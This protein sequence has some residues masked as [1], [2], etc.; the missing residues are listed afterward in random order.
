[1]AH[2]SKQRKEVNMEQ[3]ELVKTAMQYLR[4]HTSYPDIWL[5][6]LSEKKLIAIYLSTKKKLAKRS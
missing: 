5:K 6:E 1:M 3:K 2:L 4:E